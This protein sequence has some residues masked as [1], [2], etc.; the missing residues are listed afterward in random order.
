MKTLV[1]ILLSL[2]S[3]GLLAQGWVKEM[4]AIP[5]Q[6]PSVNGVSISGTGGNSDTIIN[7]TSVDYGAANFKEVYVIFHNKDGLLLDYFLL[8]TIETKNLQS[9]SE[10]FFGSERLLIHSFK[11]Q[12]GSQTVEAIDVKNKIVIWSIVGYEIKDVISSFDFTYDDILFET[13]TGDFEFIDKWS[14]NTVKS[15]SRD[16]LYTL[17]NSYSLKDSIFELRRLAGIDS[18]QYFSFFNYSPSG[19]SILNFAEYSLN[20]NCITE[21]I[22]YSHQWGWNTRY[23]FSEPIFITVN[24]NY[25]VP[26]STFSAEIRVFNFSQDTLFSQNINGPAFKGSDGSWQSPSPSAYMSMDG[27]FIVE[28]LTGRIEDLFGI[29]TFQTGNHLEFYNQDQ[30]LILES[31]VF[32]ST[33]VRTMSR[34]LRHYGQS[35]FMIYPDSSVILSLGFSY[36]VGFTGA[37]LAKINPDGFSPLSPRS[38]REFKDFSIFPNPYTSNFVIQVDDQFNPTEI[39]VY[40]LQGKEVLK[41]PWGFGDRANVEASELVPG[42]YS[43]EI[44]S[45]RRTLRSTIIKQ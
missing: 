34:P 22:E 36:K 40:N 38:L 1:T 45:D 8:P 42:I 17:V 28:Y 37:I 6:F 29:P 21:D 18:I 33:V 16:S 35:S 4:P 25:Q 11:N 24:E 12:N 10:Y 41:L 15:Y 43:V 9:S 27:N 14:G 32:S 31:E 30:N 26:D 7:V 2:S 20:C 19:Q 39:V 44:R 5:K 3:L 23:G 13:P